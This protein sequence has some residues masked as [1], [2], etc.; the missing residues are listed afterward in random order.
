VF[1]EV[2]SHRIADAEAS[3]V[4]PFFAPGERVR[5]LYTLRFSLASVTGI[6]TTD[7]RHGPVRTTGSRAILERP[8]TDLPVA[9]PS[10]KDSLK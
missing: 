10:P 6:D 4:L 5:G 9:P 3:P 2:S 8:S 7:P 1:P